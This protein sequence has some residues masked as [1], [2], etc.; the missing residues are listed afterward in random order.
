MVLGAVTS[1]TRRETD[2][3]TRDMGRVFPR[4]WDRFVGAVPRDERDGD[5]AA[6][7]AHLLASPDERVRA[8]AAARWCE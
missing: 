7:C 6:A 2:W 5:L 4:E 1:G 8:D 3:I